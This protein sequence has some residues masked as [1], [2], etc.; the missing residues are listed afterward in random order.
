M[1]EPVKIKSDNIKPIVV[2]LPPFKDIDLENKLRNLVLGQDDIISLLSSYVEMYY[3]GLADMSRPI[4]NLMFLGTTGTGKTRLA[5]ALAEVL[6]GSSRKMLKID[7]GEFQHDHEIAKLIGS[8]PGYLGHRESASRLSQKALN[9]ITSSRCDISI[10]LFDEIEKASPALRQL[11]LSIMDKAT[12]VTGNNKLVHFGRCIIILTS[13]FGMTSIVARAAT[14][15]GYAPPSDFELS[16]TDQKTIR[17]A[18]IKSFSSEFINRLDEILFFHILSPDIFTS[19][20]NLE[21]SR[22]Q[23]FLTERKIYLPLTSDLK[24]YFHNKILDNK[25]GAREIK[26][27]L[28]REF[29]I[30][31]SRVLGGTKVRPVEIT[32]T[33]S[34][35]VLSFSLTR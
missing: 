10:V 7:C 20:I 1:P 18:L 16:S 12:L 35:G 27:L 19:I 5:E 33:L 6:H 29:L 3:A 21:L 31:I 4:A 15:Y 14:S 8:P 22:Q 13:N 11:L 30:P 34:H 9:D 28:R 25:F 26:R 24:T 17:T 23:S 32:P 2:D